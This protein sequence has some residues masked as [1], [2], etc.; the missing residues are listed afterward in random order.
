MAWD[1][2]I[3]FAYSTVLTAPSPAT[4]GTSIVL[5][6][7]GGA[8]FPAAPFNIVLWPPDVLPLASNAEIVRV[9]AKA[10]DTLTITRAQENT[11]AKSVAVG[12]Q[13]AN[14]ITVKLLTDIEA[15]LDAVAILTG[16]GSPEGVVT[17]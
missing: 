9:T 4:S 8:I 1:N 15:A 2:K 14:A 17:A 6:S 3:N 16:N 7:G 10:G 12:W 11:T 13:V 5:A